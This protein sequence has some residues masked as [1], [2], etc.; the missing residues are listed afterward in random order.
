MKKRTDLHIT[1]ETFEAEARRFTSLL[2][3]YCEQ[4]QH[5][6][7][8]PY[9]LPVSPATTALAAAA[10]SAHEGIKTFLAVARIPA[11]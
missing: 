2:F 4:E 3:A 9:P 8:R 7:C 10:L 1:L 6:L 11:E 5:R